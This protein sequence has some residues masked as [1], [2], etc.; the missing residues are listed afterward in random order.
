MSMLIRDVAAL[1]ALSAFVAMIT[2]WS[3]LIVHVV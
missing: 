3:E 1:A 2:M